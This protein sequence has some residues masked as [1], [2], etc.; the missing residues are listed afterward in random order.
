MVGWLVTATMGLYVALNSETLALNYLTQTATKGNMGYI[1]RRLYEKNTKLCVIM[2]IT[3]LL[4]MVR[5][6]DLTVIRYKRLTERLR[7]TLK[8]FT[9]THLDTPYAI[10][11]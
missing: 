4:C 5:V 8:Y 10:S 1:T 9:M 3:H 6:N 7:P 2:T 11:Y